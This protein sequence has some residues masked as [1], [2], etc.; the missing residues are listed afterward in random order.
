MTRA[1]ILC[2][3][4][5]SVSQTMLLAQQV[6][7]SLSIRL[8]PS[9]PSP[10]SLS[11][12]PCMCVA[13]KSAGL[14]GWD[15]TFQSCVVEAKSGAMLALSFYSLLALLEGLLLS[16]LKNINPG[17][18]AVIRPLSVR[19]PAAPKSWCFVSTVCKFLPKA[20]LPSRRFATF[21]TCVLCER[22]A[23]F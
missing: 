22:G 19:Y 8:S 18:L 15:I 4:V 11:F 7:L 23:H 1:C 6:A 17:G 14:G 3:I 2:Y 21:E 12:L 9:P 20:A 5:V 13:I 10:L 16:S